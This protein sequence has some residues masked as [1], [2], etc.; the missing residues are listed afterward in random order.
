MYKIML[1]DDEENIIKSLK[2]VLRSQK[3][4]EVESF[5]LAEEA[6]RRATTCVFDVIISDFKMPGMDGIDFLGE[7]K[8]LQPDAMRILLTGTRESNTVMEAINHA[9]AYKFITKPW[10][11]AV[12]LQTISDAIDLR[13]QLVTN[14]FLAERSREYMLTGSVSANAEPRCIFQRPAAE[15]QYFL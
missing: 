10:D 13:M 11:D 1:V 8:E 12:L 14:R 4:W 2:R 3:D 15:P 5:T 9:G 6:L 7:M